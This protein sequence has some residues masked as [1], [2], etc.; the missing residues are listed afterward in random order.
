MT[1]YVL[2]TS[3]LVNFAVVGRSSLLMQALKFRGCWTAGVA[4]ETR[5]LSDDLP[6]GQ[7]RILEEGLGEPY[8]FDMADAKGI[9]DTRRALG[10]TKRLGRQHYGEAETIY[11]VRNHQHLCRA[12]IVIDDISAGHYARA[13]GLSVV[14]TPWILKAAFYRQLLVCPEPFELLQKMRACGR[15]VWAPT[16]H[17]DI[18]P[19]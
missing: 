13:Q 15:G 1:P 8:S 3:T 4:W 17:T 14:N 7:L 16:D 19:P 18:C 2:D 5:A 6:C 10:G 9:E 11:G 12:T